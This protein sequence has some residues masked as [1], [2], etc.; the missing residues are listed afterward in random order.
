MNAERSRGCPVCASLDV[1]MFFHRDAVPVFCNVLYP[2]V[3]EA[4]TAQ[5]GTITLGSCNACSHIYNVAFDPKRVA[6]TGAYENSL[7]F[8]P[9]FQTYAE[10]LARSLI[11][12]YNVKDTTVL[13]IGC[14]KGEFLDL[15]CT[16][17]NN[18]GIG[19]DA[20][21]VAEHITHLSP[22]RLT[23]VRENFSEHAA[24]IAAALVSCRHVLEHVSNPRALVAA[25]A[26]TA[27]NAL[28]AVVYIEVPH[29]L[30][31]FERL[32][33]WDVIYEHCA[34]FTPL[35]LRFLLEGC[36]LHVIRLYEAFDG[37]Y[38]S[39]EC[40]AQRSARDA[41]PEERTS[42]SQW[43]PFLRAFSEKYKQNVETWRT[44]LA[45][46]H[47]EGKRVVVWGGGSK[48]VTFLN[49]VDVPHTVSCVVDVNPRKH[50]LF[51]AG[52]GHRVV[53][54]QELVLHSPDVV[55]VMNRVYEQEIRT[56][57]T[58]LGLAPALFFA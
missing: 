19:F 45:A 55:I 47:S 24:R 15:L 46:L 53:S 21:Y 33:I 34:Y 31:T 6:Y 36:G 54:P 41:E 28:N 18:R 2:T 39:A 32:G 49:A 30:W 12:R 42:A 11:E 17:G 56:T 9:H 23:F 43:L 27:R 37:Q 10:Q 51:T 16:L 25:I 48:G 4:R 3:A 7:H 1:E 57:L 58:S 50:G 40:T 14:G 26:A 52:T 38:L 29:A 5:R 22:E 44:R 8:S 20:S 13:D 35:S